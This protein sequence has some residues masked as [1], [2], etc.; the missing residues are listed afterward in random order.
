MNHTPDQTSLVPRRRVGIVRDRRFLAHDPGP[1]HP[2]SPRRL[3]VLHAVLDE[4]GVRPLFTELAPR[5]ATL[6]ELFWNHTPDYIEHVRRACLQGPRSLEPDTVVSPGSWG[7]SL[8]A[9][10]GVFSA[11]DSL[12]AGGVDVA[13]ALVRPPGHHAE[14]DRAMGFCL[15][16][17]VALGA[18]YARRRLDCRRVMIVDWDL[19]H[20]N[21]T[22][23]SFYA[24]PTVLFASIHQSP[25]Y[26]GTGPLGETGTGA[27]ERYTVNIPLRAGA[28]D[29]V[30]AAAFNQVILPIG[31]TYGPDLI[32]VSAGL[33]IHWDDPLGSMEVTEN[34]IA[35]MTRRLLELAADCCGGRLLICLEG[36]YSPRGL[37]EGLMGVLSE[38]AGRAEI[39]GDP[40]N[41]LRSIRHPA[42]ELI[43]EFHGR[44]WPVINA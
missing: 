6:E 1:A 37:R 18:H 24:D 39:S 21:G 19:H 30:Y 31:K 4:P 35:Y 32:L 43:A 40:V 12:V 11:L 34:G 23:R 26:P 10:G 20:G 8:L 38:C 14:E 16:N 7:A 44:Q 2:E 3:E 33:D 5:E 25:F 36:G 9:A 22:Q 17:N 15:F 28:D 41:D 13:L 29:E 42:M 27:G